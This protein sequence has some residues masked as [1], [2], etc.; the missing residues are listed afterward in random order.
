MRVLIQNRSDAYAVPG[1]D[2]KQMQ[3]T[4]AH[5]RRLGVDVDI[6]L[7]TSPQ[8]EGYDLVHLFNLSRPDSTVLQARNAHERGVPFV[9]TPIHQLV[10]RYD[11]EGRPG[12]LSLLY[13]VAPGGMKRARSLYLRRPHLDRERDW[14]GANAA[15]ILPSSD[16]EGEQ[17]RRDFGFTTPLVTVPVG[18]ELVETPARAR[19]GV[20]CAGRI[21]PFKNQIELIRA[22]EGT[23]IPVRLAGATSPRHPR[24]AARCLSLLQRA[25]GEYLGHLGPADLAAAYAEAEVHAAPSWFESASITSLEAAWHGC[26][27]VCTEVGYARAYLQDDAG[28]C[29]P[30]DPA[31]IRTAV[32][33]ALASPAPEELRERIRTTF[34]WEHA[35]EETLAA[36]RLV[37]NGN[38]VAQDTR[39]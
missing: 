18:I 27:V 25:G 34:T 22:L 35:A 19:S 30:G 14:V 32:E 10:E 7:E 23:G 31:S 33:A 28:Y 21:E 29:D 11:R 24:W 37:R 20:L 38:P 8:L 26:R 3:E 17:L 4:A 2:T 12:G 9:L 1:G 36:Y 39:R 15:A 5:L 16:L 13:R 6:S